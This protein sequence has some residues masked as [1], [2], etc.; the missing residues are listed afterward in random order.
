VARLV[1][2]ERGNAHRIAARIQNAVITAKQ[3]DGTI[4]IKT[5]N[6]LLD[7]SPA[8]P[9]SHPIGGLGKHGAEYYNN[10]ARIVTGHGL[11]RGVSEG[12]RDLILSDAAIF[13][14]TRRR[15]KLEE[16][17]KRARTQFVQEL[18]IPMNVVNALYTPSEGYAENKLVAFAKDRIETRI[19]LQRKYIELAARINNRILSDP[20]LR[21]AV[22]LFAVVG[23][24]FTRNIATIPVKVRLE[25]RDKKLKVP[26][27]Y[28]GVIPDFDPFIVLAH[29]ADPSVKEKIVNIMREEA[30]ALGLMR[31]LDH[32]LVDTSRD[33][34]AREDELHKI[35]HSLH[36]MK[37]KVIFHGMDVYNRLRKHPQFKEF[38]RAEEE[39]YKRKLQL[40]AN[41]VLRDAIHR[42][43]K[44]LIHLNRNG[45]ITEDDLQKI[46]YALKENLS[47]TR[48]L[49]ISHAKVE[50]IIETSQKQYDA[51]LAEEEQRVIDKLISD[52]KKFNRLLHLAM[53]DKETSRVLNLLMLSMG[54]VPKLS[55]RVQRSVLAA[56]ALGLLMGREKLGKNIRDYGLAPLSP[57]VKRYKT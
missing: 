31:D 4:D 24:T 43:V 36:D 19:P 14:P 50:P 46:V 41:A 49:L 30:K 40:I 38:A 9:H 25:R 15:W 28:T 52:P 47:S 42:A 7:S 1:S 33:M 44:T 6:K 37:P 21:N 27:V 51:K 17:R 48:R 53:G 45:E 5:L 39:K 2:R 32:E 22:K 26:E 34:F 8:L 20:E 55:K 54:S 10:S 56:A 23:G 12:V 13:L 35:A 16:K 11:L 3:R 57:R 29:N 18:G